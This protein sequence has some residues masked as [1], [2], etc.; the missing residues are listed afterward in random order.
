[1]ALNTNLT[2]NEL[3]AAL[4]LVASCLDGMGGNRPADLEHDE[5]TWIDAG[6]LMKAGWNKNEAAGTLGALEAKGFTYEYDRNQLVL[7]TAA[8]RWLDTVWDANKH[9]IGR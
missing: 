1:M 6:D 5:Y 4:T 9:L 2:D 8:W 7:A 3:K